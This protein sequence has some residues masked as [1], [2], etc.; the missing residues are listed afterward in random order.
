MNGAFVD[1]LKLKP[2]RE[3]PIAAKYRVEFRRRDR[4]APRG[5]RRDRRA[6]PPRDWRAL[7]RCRIAP[8]A[9]CALDR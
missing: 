4:A 8:S 1:P 6:A 2:A 3:A 5:A 9:T 7:R